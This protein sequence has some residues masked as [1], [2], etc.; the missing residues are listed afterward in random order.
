LTY[1]VVAW[2]L[3]T[4]VQGDPNETLTALASIAGVAFTVGAILNSRRG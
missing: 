1:V 4:V 3:V 2:W